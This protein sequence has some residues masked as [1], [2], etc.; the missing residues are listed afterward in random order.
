M[1]SRRVGAHSLAFLV[2]AGLASSAWAQSTMGTIV[3]VVTDSTGGVLPGVTVTIKSQETGFTR[4]AVTDER[5]RYREGQLPVGRYEIT[6]DLSGFQPQLRRNQEV[7][8]GGEQVSNF[9]LAV[10]GIQEALEVTGEAPIVQ[11]TSAEVSALVDAQMLR[12]LPLNARDIQQLAVLQPGVQQNNYHNFG[13]QMVVSGTRPE[14]NRYLLNGV[15]MT[16]TFTT[17]P[18]SAAG[19]I[20]GV[21]A[22]Q[23]FK[24][25]TSDYSA[26]YG[27]KAGGVMNTVTK[28]GGNEFHGSG[29]EF[30]RNDAFDAR[31]FFDRGAIP[32]FDRHQYGAS[33]GGPIQRGK[34]FFFTNFESFRQRLGLSNLAIVPDQ[35]ARLGFLPDPANPGQ[36]IFVGV[37]REVSPYLALIPA[38]NGRT[39]GDGTAQFFSN[40]P[41][42]VD[43]N[44]WTIRVDR[45]LTSK[46]NLSG[47][48]T[49]DWSEE[50]TPTQNPNFADARNY[51]RQIASVENV[52][53]FGSNFL[54]TTRVGLN[55]S[56][57]FFRTD[58]TV[59]VD[60]ALYFVP[61]PF[62][63]P[64]DKG[65]FG[66]I[67]IS[68][69]K[70]LAE[71]STGVNITPRWFNYWMSSLNSDFNYNHGAH[72]FG[73]GVSYKRT[74]D[75]AVVAN[76]NSR[77]SFNFLGL[78]SFLEG[79]PATFA[80]YVPGESQLE[81]DWRHHL[82]GTYIEDHIRMN[83][84]LT[85]NLGARY[86]VLFGPSE[87]N[88]LISNLRG[89]VLDGNPT[90]G[91]PYFKQPRNLIAPRLGINWDPFGNGRT[92]VRA[93]GGIFYDQI[94]NWYYFLLAPGNAPFARNVTVAN[95]PFPNALAV[96]P[97]TSPR[98]FGAIEYEPR[99][100][101]KYSY[102]VTL[103]RE[104][105][106]RTSAMV[107]YVGSQSRHLGRGQNENL[108][109]PQIVDGQYF[110]PAGLTDRPNPAFRSINRIQFDATSSYNSFQT[111]VERRVGAGFAFRTNYTFARCED[112]LSDEFGGGA[113]NGGASLQYVRDRTS[114]RGPCSFNNDHSLNLTTTLDLPGNNLAGW[115]RAVLGGWQWSTITTAQSG[116][117]FELSLGFHNSRQGEL[118]AGPDRP[119]QVPG[120]D[121]I[122]GTPERYFDPTCFTIPAPGFL[123]NQKS[124]SLRGPTLFVTD[125]A[126]AKNVQMTSGRR[127]ELRL[128]TF[129]VLNRANF[130]VPTGRT[131]FQ[132]S[133]ARIGS[134][135]IVTRTVTPSRQVQLGIKYVF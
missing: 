115:R 80:V 45:T 27:E 83:P 37:A 47:V 33:L 96:I 78:R 52:H 72:S 68:G 23:E 59:D 118:G 111:T 70:G 103:Q 51:N 134:A 86:E 131:L 16:F 90:V 71:T 64:T 121:P 75:N 55:K 123:G 34:T 4:I 120:C 91:E 32:P 105:G 35:R 41:Q 22:V 114:S 113:L 108:F 46:D 94:N 117:P 58:T 49:G 128:E 125:W 38:P 97:P 101:T 81:R 17:A 15:D 42:K 62:Y 79:R 18:V 3:G 1:F 19:V 25:L 133:G 40:P 93:G 20:M 85:L 95:P 98:D 43:E 10:G 14:H 89:G 88:G 124:R 102:N 29:Y 99:P 21:E 77:G 104:I 53:T 2:A 119:D 44:F 112:D 109:Y 107:A 56:W 60:R 129:N 50:F 87:K 122:I 48:Y 84:R 26:A 116:V 132:P 126:V 8:V 54:N 92:S 76:P 36:E 63:A 24:L 61:D 13:T 74:L 57:Y 5:G 7:T 69:L 106:K 130:S 100:P 28:S 73:F 66:L 82:V 39:F 65:Q 127:V 12:S 110:W 67:T 31:N 9:S 11:T 30:F 135:G 6:A